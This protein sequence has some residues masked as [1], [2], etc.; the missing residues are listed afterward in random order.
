ML[1]Q[2]HFLYI[3][4]QFILLNLKDNTQQEKF[5]VTR[6]KICQPAMQS[7]KCKRNTHPNFSNPLTQIL[8][9]SLADMSFHR[10]QLIFNNVQVA[11]QKLKMQMSYISLTILHMI[12]TA[13]TYYLR[14][15]FLAVSLI[16]P[17][18]THNVPSF[19]QPV[20]HSNLP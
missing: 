5:K 6:K 3:I 7:L 10:S 4:P 15:S 18:S 8:C 20:V 12:R 17:S 1:H 19:L 14:T 11:Y 13:C 16:S 2:F 9:I